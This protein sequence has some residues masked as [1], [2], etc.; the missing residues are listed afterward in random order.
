M[1]NPEDGTPYYRERFLKRTSSIHLLVL[2]F[3]IPAAL[4]TVSPLGESAPLTSCFVQFAICPEDEREEGEPMRDQLQV[5]GQAHVT[6]ISNQ[7]EE[8][9]KGQ[10]RIN[11]AWTQF[12]SCRIFILTET[13]FPYQQN[14]NNNKTFIDFLGTFET[15][16][17][18]VFVGIRY[19]HASTCAHPHSH[20]S[21]STE[22]L[23]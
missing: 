9:T 11:V 14:G 2:R 4:L 15:N 16:K 10:K 18:V 3:A 12:I 1:G 8:L 5:F 17:H 22:L 13:Q 19:R 20:A 23:C 6:L 21:W 7:Q